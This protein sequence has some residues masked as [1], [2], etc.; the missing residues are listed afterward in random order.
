M[1]NKAIIIG[2]TGQTGAGKTTVANEL[3]SKDRLVIDADVVARNVV[4]P[5]GK[6]L[7]ILS[8]EFGDDIC[9]PDGSLNR[10]LLSQRAFSNKVN[11]NKLN[12]ITHP[13]IV[14]E[15]SNIIENNSLK[16]RI[17]IIDAPLLIESGLNKICKTVISVVAPREIR[18]KR[19]I[20]RD[21]ITK[22]DAEKRINSQKDEDF[23]RKNS[24][25]V[26]D[27]SLDKKALL[28]KAT[29]LI[30]KVGV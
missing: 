29:E 3:K 5:G 30:D 28:K 20:N 8:L 17:I 9:Y 10:L 16:Y 7:E 1:D 21:K 13:F 11:T 23:Y 22:I 25:Y 12:E 14:K 4:K 24:S 6:C 19:I 2:L 15:I 26:L 18:L 27:G